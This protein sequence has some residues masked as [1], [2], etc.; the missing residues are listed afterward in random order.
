[1]SFSMGVYRENILTMVL[2]VILGF[3]ALLSSCAEGTITRTL[4]QDPVNETKPAGKD[5]IILQA[6]SGDYPVARLHRLP[7]G[8]EK[9][10]V[11][12][13]GSAAEF[14]HVWQ[15]MSPSQTMPGIDFTK[16]IVVFSRNMHFYN[17]TSIGRVVLK[18]GVVQV[19]A[20]ETMSSLPIEDKVA[21]AL[22]VIPREGVKF[23]HTG[24]ALIPVTQETPADPLNAV[25]TIEGHEV[26][27]FRGRAEKAAAPGSATKSTIS[28]FGKPVY[29]DLDNDGNDDAAL[30]LARDLGGSGTFYYVAASLKVNGSYRGTNA[31]FLGDRIA[32]KD[33]GIQ[34]GVVVVNYAI[35]G[36]GQAM[37]AQ[38]SVGRTKYLKLEKGML[39]EIDPLSW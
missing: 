32:P 19:L 11:G 15:A 10:Q 33:V 31:V 13:I 12:Y 39:E 14:A 29:G 35:R 38:P 30:I 20:M 3:A 18:D 27:L 36:P 8:Q 1:M 17:H 25:Y 6:F 28:V 2:A 7:S 23:I 24:T 4:A 5:L 16:Y 34:D 26:R 21:M 37:T 9:Q 22:A